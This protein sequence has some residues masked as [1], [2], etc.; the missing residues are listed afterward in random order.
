MGRPRKTT[1]V[2]A[3]ATT[4]RYE[5]TQ[6]KTADALGVRI[7]T[8]M[9]WIALGCPGKGERG[10]D[11]EAIQSWRAANVKPT[12]RPTKGERDGSGRPQPP[13]VSARTVAQTKEIEAKAEW[14]TLKL[15]ERKGELISLRHAQQ[16]VE[17]FINAARVQLE[18]LPDRVVAQLR[19][20][21][22][23]KLH[24]REVLV[25][26]IGH[27]GVAVQEMMGALKSE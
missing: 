6:Q 15:Q 19:L 10:Y 26:C 25:A 21:V 9:R 7:C 20:S 27:V 13:E 23:Q 1:E 24:V 14:A 3:V 16:S 2:A 22:K 17:D 18:Q 11:L 4:A 5:P 12:G 8:V